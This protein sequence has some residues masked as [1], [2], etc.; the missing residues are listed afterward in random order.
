ML[1]HEDVTHDIIGAAIEVHQRLG[2]G[3]LESAYRR[4]LFFELAERGRRVQDE[5]T[6][7]LEYEGHRVPCCY[8]LDLLVDDVVIVEAK[9]V[10]PLHPI[11][12]AQL[13]TYLHLSGRRVGL[14]FNFKS[15]RVVDAMER[16][17]L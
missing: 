15:S 9:A 16:I 11:H 6:L 14:L 3:L 8:R 5:V 17:V 1:L 2:P 12:E 7:D 13:M 10:D 4:C